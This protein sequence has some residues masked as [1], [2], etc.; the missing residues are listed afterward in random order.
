[1][2]SRTYPRAC[3]PR[4][5]EQ[6]LTPTSSW[7][8]IKYIRFLKLGTDVAPGVM[9]GLIPTTISRSDASGM[10][11]YSMGAAADSYYEY[12]LK[13]WLL[14]GKKVSAVPSSLI[15][16]TF[17]ICRRLQCICWLRD[18]AFLAQM[19]EFL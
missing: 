18:P 14:R 2:K 10:V 12:L 1:M 19:S 8:S 13:V 7:D 15:T 5:P 3:I 6:A 16:L 4:Y 17:D 11:S 9:Q